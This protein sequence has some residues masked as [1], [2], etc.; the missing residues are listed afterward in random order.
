MKIGILTFHSVFNPGAFLQALGTQTLL[1]RMGHEPWIID[2][3]SPPHCFRPMRYFKLWHIRM[4]Y[5]FPHW[6]RMCCKNYAFE[7]ARKRLFKRT[8][9]FL[10]REELIEEEFDA[11][12]V[13]ADIVWNFKHAYLGRDP[14]YFGEG[15]NTKLL[16]SFAA[17]F[18]D[19]SLEDGLP[20]YVQEGLTN[21]DAYSVRDKNTA[22]IVRK[23]TQKEALQ[24][25]DPAFHLNLESIMPSVSKR[26]PFL[27]VYLLKGFVSHELKEAIK[28]LAR[29]ENLSI[30]ATYYTHSWADENITFLE[31]QDW[32]G[33]IRDA[34]Y[35]VTN[36]FHGS[37]F[38]IMLEKA[39]VV[40]YNNKIRLKTADMI[41]A[42][43]LSCR[44][45]HDPESLKTKLNANV[46][47]RMARS[48]Q[49]QQLK[50]A[51]DFLQVA[52]CN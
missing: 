42:M 51:S 3:T 47:Y 43:G 52:L 27:L 7:T 30:V 50:K 14:V 23:V 33:L 8:R 24:I 1:R 12:V 20:Q 4:L 2:Y 6:V 39:F 25:C 18:G 11:V 38:S 45:L 9:L 15:L 31:P 46:D 34:T 48:F 5:L 28:K 19:C 40:D 10:K 17:S 41:E 36:T 32:L 26:K 29:E 37:V 16:I 13:G 44:I 22:K 21:F 49:K 35:V